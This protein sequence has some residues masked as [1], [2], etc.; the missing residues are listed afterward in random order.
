MT[1]FPQGEARA[2][3]DHSI[4]ER[5]SPTHVALDRIVLLGC[6]WDDD[7]APA[8]GSGSHE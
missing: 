3:D 4:D 5:S 7:I 1:A 2:A 8:T 6:L